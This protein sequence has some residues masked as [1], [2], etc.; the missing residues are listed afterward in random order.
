MPCD[1]KPH[2]STHR[3]L[4]CDERFKEIVFDLFC[5]PRSLIDH[6]HEELGLLVVE[7]GL[8]FNGPFDLICRVGLEGIDQQLT[9]GAFKY[10]AVC[11]DDE[12][13]REGIGNFDFTVDRIVGLK[14]LDAVFEEH[15]DRDRGQLHGFVG[16]H[17]TELAYDGHHPVDGAFHGGNT[18]LD[19]LRLAFPDFHE[20]D[21]PHYDSE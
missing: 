20:V 10:L 18:A 3:G 5:N 15:A 14:A 6:L 8:Q 1:G 16:C 17:G 13:F 4:G 11:F 21:I 7:T 9:D 19:E 12:V 2:S